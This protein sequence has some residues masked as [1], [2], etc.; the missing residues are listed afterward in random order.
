[1]RRYRKVFE[2]FAEYAGDFYYSQSIGTDFL[3][4]KFNQ[5]GG[6]VTS[7]EHSKMKCITSG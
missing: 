2:E 6:F 5:L 4:V 7:G 1:M 3:I